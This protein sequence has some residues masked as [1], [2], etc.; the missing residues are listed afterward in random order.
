LRLAEIDRVRLC[1]VLSAAFEL[2]LAHQAFFAMAILRRA[3]ADITRRGL[4]APARDEPFPARPFKPCN[5][6][7]AASR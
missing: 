7:M 6:A 5:A 4:I 3:A 1:E 2:L